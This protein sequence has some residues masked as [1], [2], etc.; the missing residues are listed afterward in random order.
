MET[1]AGLGEFG[2]APGREL[3]FR[4]TEALCGLSCLEDQAGRLYFAA[5]LSEQLNTHVD[6]RGSKQR[7]DIIALVRAALSVSG[8]ERVLIDVVRVFE[9]APVAVEFERLFV[10]AERSG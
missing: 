10:P 5:V 1:A 4:W 3:L 2:R 7:E 9:G 6:L 8:G